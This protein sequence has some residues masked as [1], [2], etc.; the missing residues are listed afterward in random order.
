LNFHF[1][2]SNFEFRNSMDNLTIETPEQIH[3]EFPL[4]GVGSRF[5]A[6]ALDTLIQASIGSVMI[7]L[8]AVLSAILLPSFESGG[9][10]VLALMIFGWFLVQLGYFAIFEAVWN[11]QTPGK[12]LIHLRVIEDT[13][14]P[15]TT[16]ASVARNLL[17]IVDSLPGVYAVGIISAL[18]SPQNKRLGDYVAGTV[19]VH[20][21]PLEPKAAT[22]WQPVSAKPL[23]NPAF[24]TGSVLGINPMPL[25]AAIEAAPSAPS[26]YDASLLSVGEFGLIEAFLMR[27]EQL[28][29][30][31]RIQM[32]RQ[33][34]DKI[35]AKLLVRPEDLGRAEGLLEKLVVEYRNRAHYRS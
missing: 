31:V 25:R 6:L 10:W 13:G 1:R 28:D 19:V 27:R 21:R 16:Y 14:R 33:I 17:R 12:R 35:A 24:A 32:A 2:I 20:E 18:V 11:G 23:V 30:T 29:A 34:V 8:A 7:I 4:A 26:G 9:Q 15:I 22:G 5:L 3:L